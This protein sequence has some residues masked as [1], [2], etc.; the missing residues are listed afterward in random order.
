MDA[1][2]VECLTL[3]RSAMPKMRPPSAPTG[4]ISPPGNQLQPGRQMKGAHHQIHRRHT[5]QWRRASVRTQRRFNANHNRQQCHDRECRRCRQAKPFRCAATAFTAD[6]TAGAEPAHAVSP[7]MTLHACGSRARGLTPACRGTPPPRHPTLR[8][9]F[10]LA[11]RLR[12]SC[13]AS[14]TIYT[15]ESADSPRANPPTPPGGR[16]A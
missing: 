11:R 12:H 8:P 16:A 2:L 15:W 13:R 9:T 6:R 14:S 7:V 5:G 4:W 1:I 10:C 3:R